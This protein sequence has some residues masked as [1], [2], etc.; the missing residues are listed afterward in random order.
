[1]ICNC[2]FCKK[3]IKTNGGLK[4]HENYCE[5]NPN[6]RQHPLKSR[7]SFWLDR[8]PNVIIFVEDSKTSRSTVR[9]RILSQN[10]ILYKCACC[11]V[12]PYWNEKE[13]P[14]ILD[15]IN[16]IKTDNRMQNL[17][18]VCSNC[19]SQ[20]ITYKKKNRRREGRKA[21][22]L[23]GVEYHDGLIACK[24]SIPLPSS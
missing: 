16:G 1:M 15:H 7:R 23:T 13:M 24:G 2:K 3:S 22:V 5:K 19:D 14:L 6:K 10:L 20:L 17:R 8:I 4:T 12:G 11:G 21:G 18:F 9:R